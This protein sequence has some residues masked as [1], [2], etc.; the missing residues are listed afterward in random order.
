MTRDEIE[1]RVLAR[2]ARGAEASP[3]DVEFDG[4]AL[5]LYRH[6]YERGEAYRRLCDALG[7]GPDKIRSW[8]E[9]PAVPTGAFKEARLAT[10]PPEHTLRVFRTSGT[11]TP[12]RGELHL[13]T[14]ELYEASLLATFGAY[15]CPDVERL[16]FLVLAPPASEA[17]D[18]SLS[19]MYDLAA[20]RLG[21]PQ[22]RFYL[23]ACGWDP[24]GLLVDL[25][26][27]EEPVALVGTS[28]AFVHLLDFLAERGLE[29]SLPE[30]TRVMETGGFKGRSRE[31]SREQLHGAIAQRLGVPAWRIVN[32]Y[33]MCEL[34]S[35]FYEPSLRLRAPS[36][37]KRVPPWTRTRVVDPATGREA[38]PGQV[39]M[40]VHYDLANTGSVLAVQTSDAGRAV[41]GGFELLGRLP[42]AEARG[43]SLAADALLSGA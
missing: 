20:R 24:E 8:R 19:Y 42:G 16:R 30:G 35:Q 12:G 13:D 4:L 1:A 17:P 9:I 11:T 28:F 5:A 40:L 25:I 31:L 34:A 3:D 22:S 41:D 36:R 21:T 23:G 10:F 7:R 37:V 43:C 18:S 32:Q 2:I 33:G 14:L 15:I 39:G 27:L 38:A 6:Q 29:L 26:D